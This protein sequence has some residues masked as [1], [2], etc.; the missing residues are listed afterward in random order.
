MAARSRPTSRRR[1]PAR[2]A[3]L[4]AL[5]VSCA[6]TGGL[7]LLFAKVDP[8]GASANVAPSSASG[9]VGDPVATVY[10]SVQVQAQV[11]D[12]VLVDVVV[13]AYPSARSASVATNALVLPQLRTQALASQSA[14][15][16]TVSG[17]TYTSEGY[18]RSLQ[19]A[20]DNARLAGA[21]KL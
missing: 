16:H 3:R 6:A 2:V 4:G 8:S 15:V 18:A 7:T 13:L 21:T 5:V 12:G 14:R 9:F 1:R 19:S 11:R 10:G 20:L 17:A